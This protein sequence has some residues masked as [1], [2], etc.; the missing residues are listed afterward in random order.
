MTIHESFGVD[1][2]KGKDRVC[3][4]DRDERFFG[5]SKEFMKTI[6]DFE[7]GEYLIN[8]ESSLHDFTGLDERD[9]SDIQKRIQDLYGIDVSDIDSGDLTE[10]FTRIYQKTDYSGRF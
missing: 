5:I 4:N 1:H 10:I 8:D 2:L 7:P 9:L 6:F 3:F